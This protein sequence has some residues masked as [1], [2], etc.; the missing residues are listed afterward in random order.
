MGQTFAKKEDHKIDQICIDGITSDIY[1]LTSQTRALLL[2]QRELRQDMKLPAPFDNLNKHEFDGIFDGA[3]E[4]HFLRRDYLRKSTMLIAINKSSGRVLGYI[5]YD[6]VSMLPTQLSIENIRWI[7]QNL[8]MVKNNITKETSCKIMRQLFSIF[9]KKRP[10]QFYVIDA[11]HKKLAF[12]QYSEILRI[13]R[14]NGYYYLYPA[15][16]QFYELTDN[17]ILRERRVDEMSWFINQKEIKEKGVHP[18]SYF[19]NDDGEKV[20]ID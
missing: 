10:V 15:N 12:S 7:E 1:E 16:W 2:M 5:A 3:D 18:S 13:L 9:L 8:P 11:S 20:L 6:G 17:F 14:D 4:T 19:I